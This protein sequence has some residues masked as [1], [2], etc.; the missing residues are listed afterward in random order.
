MTL[1]GVELR[2]NA[3]G[4]YPLCSG[5]K[6]DADSGQEPADVFEHELAVATWRNAASICR[7]VEGASGSF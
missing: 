4:L 3:G 7:R 5:V 1:R 6:E 2:E